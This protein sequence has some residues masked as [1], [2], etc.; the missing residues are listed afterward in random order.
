M[1][2]EVLTRLRFALFLI[3]AA[4]VAHAAEFASAR[5]TLIARDGKPALETPDHKMVWLS[6]DDAVTEVLNDERLRGMDFEALGHFSS[7]DH[8]EIAPIYERPL[9]VHRDGKRLMVTY[10][11]STCYI[12]TYRPGPCWCCHKE[13]ELDL[14]ESVNP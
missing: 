12:R 13:T 11:C 2:A 6:G 4:M 8:F 1:R 9:F 14:R 10:W 3:V 5:G 7:P